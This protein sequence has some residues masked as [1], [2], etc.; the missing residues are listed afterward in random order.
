MTWPA[1]RRPHALLQTGSVRSS[2]IVLKSTRSAHPDL[3]LVVGH[4]DHLADHPDPLVEVDERD[5]DRQLLAGDRRVAVHDVRED[6]AGAGGD[7]VAAVVR[8]AG[9]ARGTGR[10]PRRAA[11]VALLDPQLAELGAVPEELRVAVDHRPHDMGGHDLLLG[12]ELEH[13]EQHL[14]HQLT[15]SVRLVDVPAVPRRHEPALTHRGVLRAGHGV[16]R[17]G[18]AGPLADPEVA[19]VG[20]FA[21]GAEH[22][23]VALLGE[24]LGHPAERVLGGA[25][26]AEPGH[27]PD[28]GHR[29]RRLVSVAEPRVL[30][31]HRV[32]PGVDRRLV[33]L[34]RRQH[35]RALTQRDD[36][37]GLGTDPL[38]LLGH[39]AITGAPAAARGRTWRSARA[40][41][42]ARRRRR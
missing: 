6:G 18:H 19:L 10:E 32:Q 40:A 35:L 24:E 22:G 28:L 12:D 21:V 16:E 31:A 42:P 1:S 5:H 33:H 37:V 27:R 14:R 20:L 23:G 17:A 38:V 29:R 25:L 30:V 2:S 9:L 11:G 8:R 4:V 26:A 39:S 7:V 41:P 34:V 36:P 3:D 13:P 15:L